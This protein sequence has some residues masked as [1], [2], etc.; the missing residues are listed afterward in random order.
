MKTRG[1]TLYIDMPSFAARL[2]DNL[3]STRGVNK[4]FEEIASFIGSFLQTGRLLDIGT[5]PGRLLAEINK[6]IPQIE[7]GNLPVYVRVDLKKE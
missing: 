5:G 3:T 1:E 2:Y 6:R 4:S 7:L